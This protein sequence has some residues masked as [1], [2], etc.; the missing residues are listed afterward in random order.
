MYRLSQNATDLEQ[1]PKGGNPVEPGNR[2]DF[3]CLF[4]YF[5]IYLEAR[6]VCDFP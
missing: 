4:V 6:S 3:A 1:I 5:D 2:S